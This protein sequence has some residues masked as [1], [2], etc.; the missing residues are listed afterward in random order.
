MRKVRLG[1]V[2][3][4]KGGGTPDKSTPEYWGGAIP[5]ASVKDFKST[6][7]NTTTDSITQLG[8]VNSSTNIIPAGTIIIPTRMAVG[9]AAINSIDLAIN[10]DLK[11]LFPKSDIF[12]KYLLN[13]LLASSEKLEQQAFGAT[14]KG[15]TLDILKNLEIPLPPIAEQKRIAEILDRTQSLISKRKEA[16]ALLDT[17]T[18]SIFLEMFGD[19]VENSKGWAKSNFAEVS[20]EK[21][22]IVDGP[23]GSTLKPDS[24]VETGVRVIRNFNIN[25]ASFDGSKFVYITRNKFIEIYRSHVCTNDILLS[26]KGT[27]GDVCLMPNLSGDSVLSASGTVRI[28]LPVNSP[29]LPYF[30]VYQMIQPHYKQYMKSF[31]AGSNQKYLNLSQIRKM[32]LIV[33]PFPLQKEFAQRVEAVEKL[34]ATHR[35]SLTELQALFASLQ[36]KAFRGEL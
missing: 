16:I 1:D 10:Q 13:F 8:V 12:T 31:E 26:T 6:E 28:R 15:I 20:P 22:L 3:D 4:I 24:Y 35:A 14:V 2:V 33:P 27:I 23:F 5:W 7:I 29:L 18:Q 11:A 36:H 30:I 9:K 19:P 21:G 17:L 32:E 25:D 34:K